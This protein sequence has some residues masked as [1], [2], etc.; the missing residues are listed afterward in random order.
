M[1]PPIETI[2]AMA[3]TRGVN[4]L[5]GELSTS[6]FSVSYAGEA[7]PFGPACAIAGSAWALSL[8]ALGLRKIAMLESRR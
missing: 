8:A 7:P 4:S 5:T 6:V 3:I 2:S 1:S